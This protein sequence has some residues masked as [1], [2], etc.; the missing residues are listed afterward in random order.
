MTAIL[1]V[2]GHLELCYVLL[3]RTPFF[4]SIFFVNVPKE[5]QCDPPGAILDHRSPV[6]LKQVIAESG[7]ESALLNILVQGYR[8]RFLPCK[9]APYTLEVVFGGRRVVALDGNLS[10]VDLLDEGMVEFCRAFSLWLGS[11]TLNSILEVLDLLQQGLR[12][13]RINGCA[14]SWGHK[15]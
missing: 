5:C 4:D 3:H 9:L 13:S 8:P 7:C 15:G 10:S 2:V 1:L 11:T 14:P 12:R 6:P